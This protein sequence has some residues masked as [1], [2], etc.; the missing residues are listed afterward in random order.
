MNVTMMQAI[1]TAAFLLAGISA[2]AAV[3]LWFR[4]NIHEVLDDLSRKKTEGQI[5]KQ[6]GKNR[7]L[8]SATAILQEEYRLILNEIVIHTKERI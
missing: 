6:N 1:S 7:D 4:L 5:L 3:I 2:I 8:E